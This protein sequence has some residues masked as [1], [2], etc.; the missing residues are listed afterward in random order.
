MS[1]FK[2]D[3]NNEEILLS[4][5]K[6]QVMMEWEKPYMEAS[7]DMLQ[8]KGDVLEIGFGCAYS[9]TQIIKHNPKSYTVIECD[10]TVL[11]KA[12]EWKK[13]YPTIPI[14]IIEGKWQDE[15]R[16]LGIFDEVYFDDFP[17]H[18]DK[19]VSSLEIGISIARFNLFVDLCIQNHTHIGSKICFYMNNNNT[20]VLGSDSTPFI[21][22]QTKTIAINIPDTCKYRDLSEQKCTIPIITKIKEY[23]FQVAQKW[24][25]EQIMSASKSAS[26]IG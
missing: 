16:S 21:E 13:Q 24:G 4:N 22:V 14:H 8:P 25:L 26:N 11:E 3:E 10:Q 17:L 23:D 12:K 9:A 5:D 2:T 1:S 15:L 20:L 18:A 6:H 7:I 19:N